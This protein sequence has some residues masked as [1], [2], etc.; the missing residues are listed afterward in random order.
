M[1]DKNLG[2]I[3]VTRDGHVKAFTS[4]HLSNRKSYKIVSK[5]EAQDHLLEATNEFLKFASLKGTSI[6]DKDLTRSLTHDIIILVI[7]GLWILHTGDFN[8]SPC[9][10]LVSVVG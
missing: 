4:Q 2:P 5:E 9:R 10:P 3:V 7:W 6:V 1:A 8:P